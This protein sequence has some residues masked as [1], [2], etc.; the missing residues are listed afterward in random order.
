LSQTQNFSKISFIF[1]EEQRLKKANE[2]KKQQKIVIQSKTQPNPPKSV[3]ITPVKT[4]TNVK[5]PTSTI[6]FDDLMRYASLKDNKQPIPKELVHIAN[7]SRTNKT[8]TPTSTSNKSSSPDTSKKKHNNPKPSNTTTNLKKA[9]TVTKTN[10]TTKPSIQSKPSVIKPKSNTSTQSLNNIKHP[11]SSTNR[12][13]NGQKPPV[14][15]TVNVQRLPTNGQKPSLTNRMINGQRSLPPVNQ[16]MTVQ[17]LPTNGQNPPNR[18]MNGQRS[19]PPN[20]MMNGHRPSIAS[21]ELKT[22]YV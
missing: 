6:S 19:L 12:M 8:L 7:I 4:V 10:S 1:A 15:Q 2:I 20:R 5:K 3:T 13:I 18:T 16:T 17:R 11:T 22:D 9:T 21:C 14:N